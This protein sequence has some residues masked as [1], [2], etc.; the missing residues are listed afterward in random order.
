MTVLLRSLRVGFAAVT[1]T[2]LAG[3][4]G[5]EPISESAFPSD[6]DAGTPEGLPALSA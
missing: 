5:E 4:A 3:C 1:M 6:Y 2:I